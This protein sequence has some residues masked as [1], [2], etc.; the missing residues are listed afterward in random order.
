MKG[1]VAQTQ[2]FKMTFQPRGPGSPSLV[3]NLPDKNLDPKVLQEL[4]PQT[5]GWQVGNETDY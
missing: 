5:P 3:P 1:A 2:I 4:W